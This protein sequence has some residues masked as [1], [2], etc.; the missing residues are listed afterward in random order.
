MDNNDK[1][2]D[3]AQPGQ[4]VTRREFVKTGALVTAGIVTGAPAILRG[5]NLNNKLNIAFIAAGGRARASMQSLTVMASRG[6]GGGG[7]GRGGRG[8]AAAEGAAAGRGA[9]A[10][11]AP[12]RGFGGGRRG[13]GAAAA[14]A[15]P[16]PDENVTVICDVNQAAVDRAAQDYPQAKKF[17][18]Y[19]RVFDSPNDFDA[20]V[21][22][23]PEH[24]H[25]I[26]TYL[27]LT[28]GKHVYCEKPLTHNVWEAR[29]IRETHAKNLRLSTQMGNQGHASAVRRTAREIIQTGVLGPIREVHVWADRAWGLQ[30]RESAL[31]FDR[32]HGFYRPPGTKPEDPGIQIVDRFKETPPI[33]ANYTDGPQTPELF[34]IWV[35]PAPARPFHPTYFPGPRWYRWWDVGN[36]TMSDLGSH[37]NDHPYTVL[38]IWREVGGQRVLAPSTIVAE[39]PMGPVAHR[40]LA[41]ATMKVTYT[42]Q[43]VGSQPALTLVWYQGNMKPPGW[44]ESW[45]GRSNIIIGEKAMLLGNGTLLTRDGKPI[46]DFQPPAETLPRSPGHWIEWL[47]YAKGETKTPPGS[48][49]QYSGWTT[50]ANHLGNVAYRTGKKLEWDYVKMVATNAPEAAPFIKR[51]QY[52]KGWNGILPGS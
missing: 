26:P 16:Q 23:T 22:A 39:S 6:G 28:M 45:G 15:A 38:D 3:K 33:P 1:T 5:Q 34:D 27:A 12:T 21:V 25:A 49:F 11:Q 20:V 4:D 14:A 30:D 37:D 42:Y 43:A 29:L 10:G 46:P 50:E 7:G 51:P 9:Q 19:R 41:P 52:R 8:G 35:G 17:N 40:E 2:P 32:Q 36:G 24:H 47:Q 44:Q 18:D 31:K 13:G 48:N